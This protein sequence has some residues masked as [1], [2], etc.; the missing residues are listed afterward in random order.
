M[1]SIKGYCLAKYDAHWYLACVL[2]VKPESNEVRLSFLHPPGPAKSFVYPSPSD[3]LFVDASDILMIVNPITA[4]GRTYT[5]T[6]SEMKKAAN[7]M[8]Y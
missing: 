8:N 3:E 5:L 4:T 1:A 6:P 7:K 2:E